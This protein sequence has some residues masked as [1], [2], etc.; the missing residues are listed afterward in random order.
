MMAVQVQPLLR[1]ILPR[2]A[3]N[4]AGKRYP[5]EILICKKSVKPMNKSQPH[6]P[7]R[8]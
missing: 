2:F 7:T 1:A 6:N 4:V 5:A 8:K 3:G